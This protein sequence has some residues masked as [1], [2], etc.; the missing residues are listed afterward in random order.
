MI[1]MDNLIA[2]IQ[3]LI[4]FRREIGQPIDQHFLPGLSRAYIQE[5]TSQYPFY[6]PEA[7]IELY[8]WH[9]GTNDEDFLMFRDMAW[10]SLENAIPEYELMMEA[11]WSEGDNEE[12]GLEPKKMFP[13]AGFTG[14][15]LYLS[16]PG[17]RMCPTLALPIIC[18]GKGVLEPYYDSFTSMLDTVEEWFTVGEH[19]EYSCK[20][21]EGIAHEIR[22]KHNADIFRNTGF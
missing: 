8:E 13:F 7:L 10:L 22:R 19:K 20:V 4:D 5:K 18:T 14:F 1:F 11:F 17:Q 12:I 16:Y 3:H 6:F 15:N 2:R 9:N 21:Q